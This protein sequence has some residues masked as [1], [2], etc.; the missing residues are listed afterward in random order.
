MHGR[1]VLSSQFEKYTY[2]LGIGSNNRVKLRLQ[3]YSSARIEEVH[4]NFTAAKLLV[5]FRFEDNRMYFTYLS[6]C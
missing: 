3:A 2:I 6:L 5:H 1:S 4:M